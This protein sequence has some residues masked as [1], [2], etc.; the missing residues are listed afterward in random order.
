MNPRRVFS[1]T[2]GLLVTLATAFAQDTR[3]VYSAYIEKYKG[4]A[5]EQMQKYR[6]PASI[7]LAQGLLE[8]DAGRS[9]LARKGNNH[10]GIKASRDW[11]GD[12][13]LADDE[14]RNE[15][16]R[17]YRNVAQSFEDHSQFLLKPRY[18]ALFKHDITDYKA[19]AKTL[20]KCGYATDPR[21]ADRLVGIIERYDLAQ[22]DRSGGGKKSKKNKKKSSMDEG[23]T[24]D[25]EMQYLHQHQ[26]GK[27]NGSYYIVVQPG[28]DLNSIARATDKS[29]RKLRSYSDIP[30]DCDVYPGMRVYLTS[31]AKSNT[32][33]GGAPHVVQNGESMHS[34]S[35]LYGVK[36]SQLYKINNLSEDY[37][38][39]VG[40]LL[41]LSK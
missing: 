12:V 8:S 19:W 27:C 20:R 17:K 18:S 22:Y 30:S 37:Q 34:I 10:F 9:R 6:I 36:L 23:Y 13:I 26:L 4:A 11:T 40:D 31:K 24:Y 39:R 5:I 33:L 35:Q 25:V 38:P 2:T 21:Y 41:Y 28:D 1:F 29:V 32:S 7:T 16:F 14:T 3:T 15:P